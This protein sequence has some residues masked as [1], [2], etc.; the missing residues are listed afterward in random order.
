VPS[1]LG[2]HSGIPALYQR[3]RRVNRFHVIHFHRASFVILLEPL[4]KN[5]VLN[6]YSIDGVVVFLNRIADF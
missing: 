6:Q 5:K 2:E 1:A 4:W 3:E